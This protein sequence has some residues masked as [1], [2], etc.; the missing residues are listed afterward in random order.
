M[1]QIKWAKQLD[2]ILDEVGFS[3]QENKLD[4][5][6]NVFEAVDKI[7]SGP[8]RKPL[9]TFMISLKMKTEEFLQQ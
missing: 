3:V 2:K 9:K 8:I 6:E 7:L 5:K 1:A 4:K